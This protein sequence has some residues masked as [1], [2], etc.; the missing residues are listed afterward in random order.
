MMAVTFTVVSGT[1]TSNFYLRYNLA[2]NLF[3]INSR[4]L[5]NLINLGAGVTLDQ[6]HPFY[7]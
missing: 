3:K 7:L 5:D 6:T 1:V 2:R 4:A